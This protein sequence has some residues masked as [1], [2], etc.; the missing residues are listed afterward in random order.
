MQ[1]GEDI[2]L[3][4]FRLDDRPYAVELARVRKVF[5]AAAINPLPSGPRVICGVLNMR[6][7]PV[8]VADLRLRLGLPSRAT[9]LEDRFLWVSADAMDLILTCD[10]VDGVSVFPRSSMLDGAE[11]PERPPVLKGVVCLPDGVLYINDP[12]TLL[13]LREKEELAYALAEHDE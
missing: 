5:R 3:L 6:G 7:R 11:I 9:A 12:D 2:Q 8:P 4:V 10:S 13:N 1:G